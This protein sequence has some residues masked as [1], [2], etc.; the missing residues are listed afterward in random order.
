MTD[1]VQKVQTE[2]VAFD[3]DGTIADTESLSGMAWAEVLADRGIT[4]SADDFSA[5]V[6]RPFEDNW[7]HFVDRGDLGPE[8]RFREELG[9]RF[10]TLFDERLEVHE[11]AVSTLRELAARGVPVAVV[12]SSTRD[13]VERVLARSEVSGC[14]THI[15]ASGDTAAHKPHPAPYLLACRR[16]D[17]APHRSTAVEDTTTGAR[18]ARAA[19]LWTV[20][21]RRAHAVDELSV[22]ADVVV[23]RLRVEDVAS[24]PV[25][26]GGERHRR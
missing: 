7:A 19:G 18:S 11:D 21:V 3:C 9:R 26:R 24:F 23:D 22:H 20:A 15:V 4:W 13:H 1:A 14:V 2:G 12:S 17:V 10:R 16:L 8:D 5:L 6:G 25:P